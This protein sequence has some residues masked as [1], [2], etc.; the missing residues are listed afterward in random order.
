MPSQS[1]II[2]STNRLL[3]HR[4]LSLQLNKGGVCAGLASIFIKYFLED[5]DEEF[6]KLSKLLANPPKNYSIGVDAKFDSFIQEVEIV[7][8][9]A[10]YNKDY[11]QGDLEKVVTIHGQPPKNE[12]NLGYTDNQ[13]E[14]AKLLEQ[15]RNNGR[16]CFVGSANHAVAL[17]FKNNQYIIFDPNYDEDEEDL[18]AT[19]P[20]FNVK[21]FDSATDAIAE[22]SKCFF[23]KKDDIGLELRVF[24]KPNA[25]TTHNYPDK[26]EIWAKRLKVKADFERKS[27]H[28]GSSSPLNFAIRAND[29]ETME[30][31]REQG[32]ISLLEA[33][34][35]IFWGRKELVLKYLSKLTNPI[36]QIELLNYAAHYG[37]VEL[38]KEVLAECEKKIVYDVDGRVNPEGE[39]FFKEA[40]NQNPSL[41]YYAAMSNYRDNV[42]AVVA[43]YK[44]YSIN[45]N[46]SPGFN[47]AALLEAVSEK[48]GGEVLELTTELLRYSPER[49]LSLIS[50]A[51]KNNNRSGLRFWIQKLTSQ[52]PKQREEV[53][54][55]EVLRAVSPINLQFLLNSAFPIKPALLST[56]LLHENTEVFKITVAQQVPSEWT[57]FLAAVAEDENLDEFDSLC[58]N[59]FQDHDGLNAFEVLARFG[60]NTLIKRH[61]PA[62][63]TLA[64]QERAFK[65]ACLNADS[66]LV[67]FLAD[68]GLNA[69]DNFKLEQLKSAAKHEDGL[70]ADALLA[71][72]IPPTLLL[73]KNASSDD[74]EQ[75]LLIYRLIH[76]GKYHFITNA[77]SNLDNDLKKSVLAAALFLRNKP[78]MQFI[79]NNELLMAKKAIYNNIVSAYTKKR[80]SDL[81]ELVPFLALADR[82]QLT[83][84][85]PQV[86]SKKPEAA[87]YALKY[88]ILNHH[89]QLAEM[90][91]DAIPLGADGLYELFV[92]AHEQN[93]GE[94]IEFIKDNYDFMLKKPEL[95]TRLDQDGHFAA[96]ATALRYQSTLP[97]PIKLNLLNSAASRGDAKIIQLLASSINAAS[98]AEGSPLYKALVNKHAEGAYLL[99]AN[100]ASFREYPLPPALFT[101][102][103]DTNDFRLFARALQD[104]DFN[105]FLSLNLAENVNYVLARAKPEL[106]SALAQKVSLSNFYEQFMDYAI[107]HNDVALFRQ[108]QRVDKYKVQDKR[109]LFLRVCAAKS[110][111]LANELV[112]EPITF[113]NERERHR[114]LATLF[115]KTDATHEHPYVDAHDVYELVYHR[116]LNRLY[117]YIKDHRFPTAFNSLHKSIEQM[118]FDPGLIRKTELWGNLISRALGEG[119]RVKLQTL[120]A[121]LA[122][123]PS[124]LEGGFELFSPHLANPLIAKVL[125]ENYSL[126]DFLNVA[127]AKQ[128]WDT[129]VAL[130]LGRQQ[131]E[132][133]P[134][135]LV[136]LANYKTELL[137]GLQSYAMTQ[138]AEDPRSRL[139]DLLLD[140]STEVLSL[141]L[142]SKTEE[143]QVLIEQVQDEMVKA[144]INLKRQFYRFDLY[145]QILKDFA[146]IDRL[147]PQ[148]KSLLK[149]CVDIPANEVIA[150]E[151]WRLA[152]TGLKN[153]IATNG[154][155]P[156]YFN[157]RNRLIDLFD[158]LDQYQQQE[159]QSRQLEEARQE[160]LRREIEAEQLRQ[161]E[162]AAEQRRQ[163]ELEE[164][165]RREEVEAKQ[166]QQRELE[167]QRRREALEAKQQQ[168]REL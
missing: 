111:D 138:L 48:S 93:N 44:K 161:E 28:E 104:N 157:K 2:N 60:K 64:E 25:Q 43:V 26:K 24:A 63:L 129:V 68:R 70:R 67:R 150:N 32:Y 82:S 45:V 88:A 107:S 38:F 80:P 5:R 119:D 165:R 90:M 7:F 37:N 149:D 46:T 113:V 62:S 159:K 14:W 79:L 3:K 121:Q 128:K 105:L 166:Q 97:I 151:A 15:I 81:A 34:I 22:L 164:Q 6:F 50:T 53:I 99:L 66:D 4:G 35:A 21:T 98:S 84:Y 162:L 143:I 76:L 78:L 74:F 112:E 132:F 131:A 19:L 110:V 146:A 10:V 8:N 91:K 61:W 77:W 40:V 69:D 57:R 147:K 87:R 156:H 106:V 31:I 23:Y 83:E 9:P 142:R 102:A 117:L 59:L 127:I 137:A 52:T 65:F 36:E 118:I 47:A 11:H 136:E 141:V 41:L 92:E 126:R 56:A 163:R 58:Q 42:A 148:I 155:S 152:L 115:E 108:L 120:M 114:A 18:R 86:F 72:R 116:A 123:R 27:E 54:T 103:V 167:E 89:F 94:A 122:T 125:L 85:W 51:A 49:V 33:K 144:G 55:A 145:A 16:A 100:G 109:S 1:K 158:S 75:S 130:L 96:L 30:Y 20:K 17:A 135:F 95:F 101:F 140:K 154:L 160:E 12:Y 73:A 153:E 133:D 124:L 139:N 134:E 168:Q 71:A 13:I 39:D 29:Q